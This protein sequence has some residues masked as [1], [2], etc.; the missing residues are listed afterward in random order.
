MALDRDLNKDIDDKRADEDDGE[1]EIEIEVVSDE[2]ASGSQPLDAKRSNDDGGGAPANE[3]QEQR[4]A[5]RKL[6]RRAVKD[7]RQAYAQADH[8]LISTLTSDIQRLEARLQH[9]EGQIIER[10]KASL[11][12]TREHWRRRVG[13]LRGKV[14]QA[15]NNEDLG[16]YAQ[17]NEEL[18]HAEAQAHQYTAAIEHHEEIARNRPPPEEPISHGARENSAVFIAR[19]PWYGQRGYERETAAVGALDEEVAR[20]KYDPASS[21]Y[22]VKLERLMR[23]HGQ[24]ANPDLF[25]N[26]VGEDDGDDDGDEPAPQPRDQGGRF[27][28]PQRQLPARG[29]PPTGGRQGAPVEKPR[30]KITREDEQMIKDAGFWDDRKKREKMAKAIVENKEKWATRRR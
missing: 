1:G 10:D 16:A 14:K 11:V 8:A 25:A 22:F 23:E 19:F 4:S 28:P 12:G 18:N 30:I 24:L 26:A 15:L 13:T 21:A 5:R 3:T 7:N 20:Q 17:F 2:E 9:H 27:A 6:E 29:G